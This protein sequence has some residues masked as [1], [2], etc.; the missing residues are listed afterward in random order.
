MGRHSWCKECV[1]FYNRM[2]RD[3]Q[4]TAEQSSLNNLYT[5]YRLRPE[6]RDQ[7]L[8][9]QA[10]QCAICRTE[11]TA[12]N[13]RIDHDHATDLVRGILCHSCNLKLHVIEDPEFMEAAL[14]YLA[15]HLSRQSM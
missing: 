4:K 9:D 15:D 5:R 3:Y 6:D 11:L 14:A 2:T 8:E 7:M 13:M 12:K 1:N 10:H